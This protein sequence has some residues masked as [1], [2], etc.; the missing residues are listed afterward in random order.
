MEQAIM[1]KGSSCDYKNQGRISRG[2]K[3]VAIKGAEK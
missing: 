3:G 1:K 2:S